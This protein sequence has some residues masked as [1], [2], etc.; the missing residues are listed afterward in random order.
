MPRIVALLGLLLGLAAAAPLPAQEPGPYE[1]EA[2]VASQEEADRLAALPAALAQVFI[3]RT[4]DR[5]AADD[6]RLAA[7]LAQAG[8]WMVQY[9]YRLDSATV[10]G[11]PEQRTTLI[12][13]F[14][15]AA[16]DRALADASRQ[17]W[18]EPRPEPVVWLAI[19]DGRGARLLGAGQAQAVSALTA[20]ARQRGLRLTYPLLDLEDQG[21][22]D[23]Q[24][25]WNFDLAAAQQ[26]S[27]RYQSG[28][29]LVGR[30][31]RQD[32]Q[33]V[34]EWRVLQDG[35]LLAQERVLDPDSA[36]ALAAGADLAARALAAH[37]ASE[38]AS[39]GPPG[40]Y[41]VRVAGIRSAEDYARLM[42][43]LRRMSVVR[44]I[45]VTAA[46]GDALRLSLDLAAGIA[47]F[48]RSARGLGLLADEEA[49]RSASVLPDEAHHFRLLP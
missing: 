11:L 5:G 33:W 17:I 47:G 37:F 3:K 45:E 36:N 10:G 21:R 27:L 1:G 14:D 13:R 19:D 28:A 49:P 41:A 31:F 4:G 25:V 18:P 6:P 29:V 42:G 2:R 30:L 38:L 32:T 7:A 48:A 44:S 8:A 9:R 46:E 20:R 16:V 22:I 15:A 43:Q 39:A 24:R 23:A 34:A 26:A 12:A 35:A 40:R